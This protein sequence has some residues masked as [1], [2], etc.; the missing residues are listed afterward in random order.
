V[1]LAIEIEVESTWPEEFLAEAHKER[2]LVIDYQQERQRIDRLVRENV[3]GRTF[4]PSNR[5]EPEFRDLVSQLDTILMPHRLVGYHC[6]RLTPREIAGIKTEG[7]RTL[8]P[9]LVQEK[10]RGCVSDGYLT[11]DRG[12]FLLQHDFQISALSDRHGRRTGMTW[13]C[14]NRSTLRIPSLVY[15]LFRYWGGEATRGGPAGHPDILREIEHIGMPCIVKCAV[16][17]VI[18][19]Q[20]LASYAERFLSRFVAEAVEHPYPTA[21]FDLYTENDLPCTN[22]LAVIEF[23]DA[24]FEGLTGSNGW[25]EDENL[26]PN[27]PQGS[28]HSDTGQ[29]IVTP[30]A[31]R[32]P[33]LEISEVECAEIISRLEREI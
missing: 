22:V 19:R 26:S 8:S 3:I 29:A 13:F 12:D 10:I 33:A 30:S 32:R 17:F 28:R 1:Q 25:R 14:P 31:D 27:P 4:P 7:M 2:S 21:D 16:P 5:Y 24:E 11:S 15:R 23:A 9:N 20:Y 18:A 6:T